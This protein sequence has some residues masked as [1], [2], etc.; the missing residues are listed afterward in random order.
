MPYACNGQTFFTSVCQLREVWC[1]EIAVHSVKRALFSVSSFFV[2]YLAVQFG[3]PSGSGDF[4]H[5]SLALTLFSAWVGEK[6]VL[7]VVVCN[8]G[9]NLGELLWFDVGCVKQYLI[10][11]GFGVKLRSASWP[12]FSPHRQPIAGFVPCI[13]GTTLFDPSYIVIQLTKAYLHLGIFPLFFD[14]NQR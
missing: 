9:R 14:K 5:S 4:F 1:N 6:L 12:V 10:F 11:Y 3:Y 13:A 7:L 8:T 2:V